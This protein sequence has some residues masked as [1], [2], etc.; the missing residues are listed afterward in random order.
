MHHGVLQISAS[1]GSGKTYTLAKRYIMLLLFEQGSDGKL[2]YRRAA[3]YHSHI[4]AITFTNQATDEMKLRIV[5]E[6]YLLAT[7]T[8]Q[9]DFWNDFQRM[10]QEQ[11]CWADGVLDPQRMRQAAQCA[12]A[13]LLYDYGTFN[14]STID[15]F[16][17]GIL[18]NFAR[19]LDRDY[20]YEVQIDE[21]LALRTAIHNFLLSLGAG[22]RRAGSG[23]TDV[24]EWVK[25]HISQQVDA[26][27]DWNLFRDNGALM[28]VASMMN[29]EFFRKH[30]PQLSDYLT[31]QDKGTRV[32]DL[33]RIKEFKKRLLALIK[34]YEER[35]KAL[36]SSMNQ[37]IDQHGVDRGFI[38]GGNKLVNS[39]MQPENVIARGEQYSEGVAE[40]TEEKLVKNSFKAKYQPPLGFVEAVMQWSHEVII[41]WHTWQMLA[42]LPHELGLLG[43]LNRI[44][45]NVKQYSRETNQLLI[46]DTNDLIARVLDSGV[47]F[48]YE[49]VGTWINHFMIDEFQD[50]SRKQYDNFKPLLYEALSHSGE[51][52][53]MLIGDA[54]QSI[55]RF[56]NADP[57]LFRDAIGQ[58]F[59]ATRHGLQQLTLD[60]NYR[61]CPAIVEFNNWLFDQLLQLPECA[62][63][64]ML[65]RT[66]M[67]NG[68]L[69]DFQQHKHKS[70]PTGMVRV[71]IM[72]SDKD[73]PKE[74]DQVLQLLP[75]YLNE[76]HQR[77][78]WGQIG[79]LVK[80]NDDGRDVV[81][82]I[83]E[84][85]KTADSHRQ[86]AVAS[87]ESML[88]SASPSVKRIVSLLRFIDLTQY[89]LPQDTPDNETDASTLRKQVRKQLSKQRLFHVLGLFMQHMAAGD[90]Q[91]AGLTLEQCFKQATELEQLSL[92]EQAA[93]YADELD[94]LLP[95]RSTELMSLTNIVE[96]I[97][98]RYIHDTHTTPLETAH[99]L[100]FQDCVNDFAQQRSGG[101][102]REFLEY[103]ENKKS[104]LTVPASTTN[105]AVTVLTIHKSKGLEFDCVVIPFASWLLEGEVSN[106]DLK[107]KIFWVHRQQFLDEGG[108]AIVAQSGITDDMIPPILPLNK[109]EVRKLAATGTCLQNFVDHYDQD[110]LVDNMDK[111]Y[112]ALTRPKQ[113][114]HIFSYGKGL[115]EVLQAVLEQ[116]AQSSDPDVKLTKV[117]QNIYQ[118]GKERDTSLDKPKPGNSN[119]NSNSNSHTES[120]A[121]PP[122]QVASGTTRLAV[123]LP[124]DLT[125]KQNTGTRL[126]NLLSRIAYRRDVER[127]WGFCLNRGIIR[128][129]DN[130]WPLE[131]IRGIIDRMF[132]DPRT[133]DWFADDNRVYNERNLSAGHQSGTTRRPDRV[134]R[135]PDGS[136]IVV[137][138]KFGEKNDAHT[139]Q[140]KG[141]M[142]RLTHMG[143]THVSG[144]VWYVALDEV[145]PVSL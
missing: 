85:N 33:S 25:Q 81:K 110:V 68:Q 47:P 107:S 19:E 13:S 136:W 61:S 71:H 91:D 125:D 18:R 16:F 135:R 129:D 117:D 121:M 126:H 93:A 111:T 80:K 131:R 76:L 20:N 29:N 143:K 69:T 75:D 17:Q 35:Y 5:D 3:G 64:S 38:S 72:S 78:G 130:E 119:S 24:E 9:S 23:Q 63:S 123:R 52:L 37:L 79:I 70:S 102:V 96:H 109:A 137:D 104:K 55:Y 12:L 31:R 87:D 108:A 11:Q 7:A 90:S 66:Y 82:R 46:A 127:A 100:A 112:V 2:N 132:D 22:I 59:G 40:L 144:Y 54:K 45:D 142:N 60:T 42:K 77:F 44:D 53:C 101:T 10:E 1:A 113:E 105:D 36:G 89:Q 124:E 39:Y 4:L 14:V 103:W 98:A 106:M 56:R 86:I 145:D 122:Y 32:P 67:P 141:Y 115:S 51:N 30:M 128:T 49:R 8:E 83:M 140:V 84:Y 92:D 26:G 134:V 138:Y 114:L 65:R 120:L 34:G 73:T 6:L 116:G 139:Q 15:S 95:D 50:T 133:S 88:V 41:T 43:L 118:W 58:D 57:S 62:G 27:K 99:L 97:I 21:D 48:V 94:R 74:C 28:S